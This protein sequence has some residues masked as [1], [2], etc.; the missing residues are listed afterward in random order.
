MSRTRGQSR[1]DDVQEKT[2]RTGWNCQTNTNF[3]IK[4]FAFQSDIYCQRDHCLALS[5]TPHFMTLVHL[6]GRTLAD[7]DINTKLVDIV[8][9]NADVDV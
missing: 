3:L 7:E 9:K 5:Q 8:A 1:I 2:N 6:K 4:V